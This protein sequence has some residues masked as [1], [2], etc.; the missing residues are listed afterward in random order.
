MIGLRSLL[1]LTQSL[2]KCSSTVTA[3]NSHIT[4]SLQTLSNRFVISTKDTQTT[5]I[6]CRFFM[7]S[8]VKQTGKSSPT[9]NHTPNIGEY[10]TL[11]EYHAYDMIHKL[12]ENDRAS[13]LKALNKFNS[14]K[15]KSKFQGNFSV[16]LLS[17]IAYLKNTV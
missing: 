16:C 15:I 3:I 14:D 9:S 8:V 10:D 5:Y 6:S 7:C 13:L 11:T 17:C 4:V 2:P 1:N 12:S